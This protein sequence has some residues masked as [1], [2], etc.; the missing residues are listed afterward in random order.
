MKSRWE[1]Y[2]RDYRIAI[3]DA[4]RRLPL[5]VLLSLTITALDLIGVGLIAPFVSVLLGQSLDLRWIEAAMESVGLPGWG[6]FQ[7]LGVTVM[8]VFLIK[9]VL[10]FFLQKRIASFAENRRAEL[11]A[12]LLR[13]FQARPYEFHLKHNSSELVNKVVYLTS[14]YSA[15]TLQS[16]LRLAADGLVLVAIVAFLFVTDWQ[17]VLILVSLLGGVFWIVSGAVRRISARVTQAGYRAGAQV[18]GATQQ[19]LGGYKEVRILAREQYFRDRLDHWAQ[20]L[21]RA[22]AANSALAVVPKQAVEAA[23]IWFLVILSFFAVRW[24][25]DGLALVPLLGTFAVAAVRLMPVVTSL[26]SSFTLLRAQRE[27]LRELVEDIRA[28][29]ELG[30]GSIPASPTPIAQLRFQQLDVDKVSFGYPDRAERTLDD[31]SLSIRRGE[32]VGIMGRSGAG[33]STLADIILGLLVPQLGKVLV[34]GR[35]I[36]E[37]LREWHA[38]LAYIPQTIYLIDDTLRRNIAFGVDDAKIDAA[39]VEQA[40]EQA[41]LRDLVAQLPEGL[42]T[43]V[44]E[45]GVRLSGGQRQRVAIARA[46]YHERE[47]L[48]LDEAT[49]ALDAETEREIVRAMG[50]LHGRKTLVVIA[51]KASVLAD[52]DVVFHLQGGRLESVER[53]SSAA[54]EPAP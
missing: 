21:A 14:N 31:V 3:G 37:D 19:A 48:I 45:R 25:A 11:M 23:V 33:K 13:S 10:A 50:A 27:L 30:A 9:G 41:Q 39:R 43:V 28:A 6:A 29:R 24:R 49:S 51:H 22:V 26:L 40:I 44:G 47:F 15:G 34:N 54:A 35:D 36:H 12:M 42:D 16:S 17:A 32:L 8:L 52:A 4:W 46:L 38:K 2:F 53:R 7:V 1:G 18:I 5:V 20:E